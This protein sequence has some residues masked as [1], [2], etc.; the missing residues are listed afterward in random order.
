M[1]AKLNELLS[2]STV[3]NKLAVDPEEND[4][5]FVPFFTTTGAT[6]RMA[7]DS[8]F[9]PIFDPG[10]RHA[11]CREAI[12]ETKTRQ[13]EY[14]RPLQNQCFQQGLLRRHWRHQSLW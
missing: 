12:E 7:W 14:L 9:R 11:S 4:T 2:S 3:T 1:A 10:R 13:P 8:L 6:P 5:L